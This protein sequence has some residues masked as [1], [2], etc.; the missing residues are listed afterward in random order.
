MGLAVIPAVAL[1][2][3]GCGGFSASQGVS[4]ASFFLPGLLKA[5]PPPAQPERALP[6]E[7]P[8]TQV[9]QS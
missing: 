7:E 1:M 5:D 3:T 4:P 2:V 8:G 9:A 6:P